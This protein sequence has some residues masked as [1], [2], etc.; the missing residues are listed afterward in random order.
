MTFIVGT[1]HTHNAGYFR[2][3]DR[4]S[5]GKLSEADVQT[6]P[7]CQGLIK[8]QEWHLDGGW[9]AKCQAPLCNVPACVE[10]TSRL[11]CV[12]FSRKLEA[13]IRERFRAPP[14]EAI[15]SNIIV[16]GS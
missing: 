5:G 15:K 6:C 4:L 16:G 14:L 8:M 9:C 1:P 7:H 2:N 11:G 10:E 3:D 13:L 12:P